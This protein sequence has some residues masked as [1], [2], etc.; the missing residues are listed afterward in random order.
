[1][2]ARGAGG[3]LTIVRRA[4]VAPHVTGSRGYD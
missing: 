2:C 3:T 4:V 1:M